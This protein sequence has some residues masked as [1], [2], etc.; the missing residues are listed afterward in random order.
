MDRPG[1]TEPSRPKPALGPLCLPGRADQLCDT[2]MTQLSGPERSR[3]D[4][5]VQTGWLNRWSRRNIKEICERITYRPRGGETPLTGPGRT[6]HCQGASHRWERLTR[7]KEPT[8]TGKKKCRHWVSNPPEK[9][10]KLWGAFEIN[11][12]KAHLKDLLCDNH[13]N[14]PKDRFNLRDRHDPLR[15]AGPFAVIVKK[16]KWETFDTSCLTRRMF[17]LWKVLHAEPLCFSFLGEKRH[18]E[19]LFLKNPQRKRLSSSFPA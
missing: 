2:L 11:E 1:R 4:Q 5:T 16:S 3:T 9:T 10:R 14:A 18:G 17:L 15:T 8:N 13:Q 7:E 12:R 19:N 6:V